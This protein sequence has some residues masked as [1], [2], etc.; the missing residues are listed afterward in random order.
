MNYRYYLQIFIIGMAIFSMFF[1]GGNLTFPL[2]I[3]SET[4]SITLSSLGFILSGVLLPFY[5]IIVSLYFKGDYETYLNSCGKMIGSLL[6]FALL[7]FWIPLGSGPRC[8]Q[9]AF[10]AF[11]CQIGW[12]IPLWAYSAAYSVFV[13]LLTFRENRVIEILGK[14][15]TPL[16]I[17]ALFFLIYS[18]FTNNPSDGASLTKIAY[19]KGHDL[20]SSFF[21]GYHTMDFI[22]AIFFSSTV[23]GLI[24]EKQKDKFNLSLVRNA[25]LMAII[26]LSVIYVGLIYVGYANAEILTNVPKDRL[27][28]VIGQS[29]L[30]EKFQ[31]IIFM[32]ITLSVLSTSMALSL[33]FSDYLR[34]V[35]FKNRLNHQTCLFIS[36]FI[37]FVM[38]IIG[39]E[40]LAVIISY[41]TTILY[42]LLLIVTTIAFAKAVFG[43]KS[44]QTSS[45]SCMKETPC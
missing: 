6:V 8:N 11:S 15:M 12:D 13:Y 41:A 35:I 9:L 38:S 16:L 24:K 7:L 14:V 44:P 30:G 33:V 20:S 45:D 26:L 5:G 36:I 31:V 37:S 29:L 34:K 25:C 23:I 28:A 1:G 43:F 4:S 18:V 19:S 27:L 39:F 21:A 42:P 32:I 3:G 40:K 22:A 2:W 17:F 10:G